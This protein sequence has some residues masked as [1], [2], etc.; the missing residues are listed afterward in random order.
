MSI[1]QANPSAV[2]SSSID[3]QGFGSK[4][5]MI[6]HLQGSQRQIQEPRHDLRNQGLHVSSKEQRQ[7]IV[8]TSQVMNVQKGSSTQNFYQSQMIPPQHLA[9][10]QGFPM[11]PQASVHS[12]QQSHMGG[13][14]VHQQAHISF[15]NSRSP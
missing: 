7:E 2:G 13:K 8:V 12:K 10:P 15:N 3:H 11:S 14:M 4:G 5:S 1:G 9:G 6:D